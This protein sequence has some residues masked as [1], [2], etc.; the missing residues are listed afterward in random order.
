MEMTVEHMSRRGFWG[1]A[2]EHFSTRFLVL[3]NVWTSG[4]IFFKV[5][6]HTYGSF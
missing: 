5:E 6:F 4:G 2:N 3:Y 1:K